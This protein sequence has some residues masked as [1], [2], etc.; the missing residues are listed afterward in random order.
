MTAARDVGV[1]CT[2]SVAGIVVPAQLSNTTPAVRRAMRPIVL[3]AGLSNNLIGFAPSTSA[4]SGFTVSFDLPYLVTPTNVNA[5]LSTAGVTVSLQFGTAGGVSVTN[6]QYTS[7]AVSAQENG[8]VGITISYESSSVPT[9]GATVTAAVTSLD[10]FKFSDVTSFQGVSGTVYTDVTRVGMTVTR[11]LA[12]YGGNSTTGIPKYLKGTHVEVSA[13]GEYMKVGDGEGTAWLGGG[14]PNFCPTKASIIIIL[15]QICPSA[16]P[17]TFT[18]TAANC[19]LD[20][21]PTAT[22]GVEDWISETSTGI[23]YSGSFT[24]AA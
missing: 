20:E 15:T 22:G 6:C 21:Y 16:S 14:T 24:I 17:A 3:A 2:L 19:F 10:P 18:F 12:R 1:S 7:F 13:M 11:T 4:R 8:N 5:M 23:S 9:V